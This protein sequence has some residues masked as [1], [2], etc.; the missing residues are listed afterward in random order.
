MVLTKAEEAETGAMLLRTKET[1]V[2]DILLFYVCLFTEVAF[3]NL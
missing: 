2:R 1:N 3:E